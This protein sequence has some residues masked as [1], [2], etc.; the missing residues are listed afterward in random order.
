MFLQ[1][2]FCEKREYIGLK[3]RDIAQ[4]CFWWWVCVPI[5]SSRGNNG[6]VTRTNIFDEKQLTFAEILRNIL[7]F[8]FVNIW[9][10][11]KLSAKPNCFLELGSPVPP[12]FAALQS[13][14]RYV[15][16]TWSYKNGTLFQERPV[17]YRISHDPAYKKCW[18]RSNLC[19]H[20][21]LTFHLAF[22]I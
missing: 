20:F 14:Y 21:S 8:N 2:N 5:C 6:Y 19:E 1:K 17:V 9:K 11:Q 22:P 12:L 4:K 13:S 15:L 18:N 3:T 7:Q 16:G 10:P